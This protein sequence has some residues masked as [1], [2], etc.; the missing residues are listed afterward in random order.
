MSKK[1]SVKGLSFF[2]LA[3][4]L[5]QGAADG[6]ECVADLGSEQTH[7][8]DHNDGDEGENDRVLNESLTSF[9]GCK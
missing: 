6:T 8:G 7:D 1:S 9:F 4:G 5:R 2:A 3:S